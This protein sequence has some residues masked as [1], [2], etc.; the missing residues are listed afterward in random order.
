MAWITYKW[1]GC[2]IIEEIDEGSAIVR[3]EEGRAYG[4]F[5]SADD[6]AFEAEWRK[7]FDI[8]V[9]ESHDYEYADHEKP[10]VQ[11]GEWY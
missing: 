4:P 2:W 9:P 1:R 7:S 11:H 8:D 5:E 6:A 3:C 10:I